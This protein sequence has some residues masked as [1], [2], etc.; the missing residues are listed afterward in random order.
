M[1]MKKDFL[2]ICLLALFACSH[3]EEVPETGSVAVNVTVEEIGP[4]VARICAT[5]SGTEE[6]SDAFFSVSLADEPSVSSASTLTFNTNKL[7]DGKMSILFS[8]LSPVTTYY[9]KTRFIHNGENYDTPVKD[10]TTKD[11]PGGLVDMGLSVK[12]ASCNLGAGSPEGTGDR[13]AWG[14]TAPKSAFS[15]ENYKWCKGTKDSIDKYNG[16]DGLSVLLPEDDA[17]TAALGAAWHIPTLEEVTELIE[18]SYWSW[19]A[20]H[21]A[22]GLA[23]T[24]KITGNAIFFPAADKGVVGNPEGLYWTANVQGESDAACIRSWNGFAPFY[25][26]VPINGGLSCQ[27]RCEGAVI[28]PVSK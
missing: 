8:S 2:I 23:A 16:A 4:C 13:Y 15:W 24:S 9:F 27:D 6:L 3:K 19:A 21:S 1:S 12:W 18:N 10:F 14:E 28:R 11:L 5:V 22:Q 7:A 26:L 20:Y 17:A 25:P